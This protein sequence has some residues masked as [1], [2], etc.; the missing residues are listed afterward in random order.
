MNKV[1]LILMIF[2]V[3]CIVLILVSPVTAAIT[4]IVGLVL[5]RGQ[6]YNRTWGYSRPSIS[7]I[8]RWMVIYAVVWLVLSILTKV[9]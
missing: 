3:G 9:F 2:M 6:F 7:G 5:S 1:P 4:S 8:V